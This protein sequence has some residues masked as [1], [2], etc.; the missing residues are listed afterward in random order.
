MANRASELLQKEDT[1]KKVSD[2]QSWLSVHDR[3]YAR[4]K[5]LPTTFNAATMYEKMLNSETEMPA[6][7]LAKN[8]PKELDSLQRGQEVETHMDEAIR[9]C[10]MHKSEPKQQYPLNHAFLV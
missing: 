6:F 5:L 1:E 7:D 10:R 2:T 9:R 8:E 4:V 3:G